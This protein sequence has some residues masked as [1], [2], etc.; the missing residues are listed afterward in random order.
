M[1]NFEEIIQENSNLKEII[2]LE[3]L[4]SVHLVEL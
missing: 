3:P 4:D 1:Q 2:T